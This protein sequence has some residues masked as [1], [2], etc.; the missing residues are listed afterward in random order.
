[1]PRSNTGE[2]LFKTSTSRR[3]KTMSF[4]AMVPNTKGSDLIELSVVKGIATFMFNRPDRRNAMS[5]DRRSAF[6]AALE[7]V[8]ADKAIKAMVITGRGKGFCAGGDVAGMEKRMTALPGEVG[9]NG[10]A[11][12]QRV[13]YTQSLQGSATALALA[14]PFSTNASSCRPSRSSPKAVRRWAF[15]TP[16]ANIGNL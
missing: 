5:D 2:K 6:I 3:T 4:N 12:Q 13:H 1:M 11:R 15:A 9:F 16:V 8:T 10:W 7:R 14:K